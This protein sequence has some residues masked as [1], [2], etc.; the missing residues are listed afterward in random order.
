MENLNNKF[1]DSCHQ[2]AMKLSVELRALV[3]FIKHVEYKQVVIYSLYM[4]PK[5]MTMEICEQLIALGIFPCGI[6]KETNCVILV[7]DIGYKNYLEDMY[8][9]E[10]ILA[11]EAIKKALGKSAK[12]IDE[13]YLEV[14]GS[15]VVDARY[16]MYKRIQELIKI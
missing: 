10:C 12:Y 8:H 5:E 2:M 13:L 7:G 14:L 9:R 4:E 6:F 1:N 16:P 11:E 3:T 15:N